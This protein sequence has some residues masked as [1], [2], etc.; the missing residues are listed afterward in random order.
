MLI[1]VLVGLDDLPLSWTASAVAAQ[2]ETGALQLD[3]F[4]LTHNTKN[5]TQPRER[6]N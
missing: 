6:T 4:S 3:W 5:T 1:A 2:L